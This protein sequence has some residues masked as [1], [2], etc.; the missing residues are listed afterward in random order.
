VIYQAATQ[1]PLPLNR[2]SNAMAEIAKTQQNLLTPPLKE[3][4]KA[5]ALSAKRARALADA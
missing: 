1:M 3:L 4:Q 5:L 2:G